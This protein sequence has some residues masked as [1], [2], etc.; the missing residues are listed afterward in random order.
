MDP[1]GRAAGQQTIPTSRPFSEGQQKGDPACLQGSKSVQ[2][3]FTSV[4]LRIHSRRLEGSGDEAV[5]SRRWFQSGGLA[6]TLARPPR[7]AKWGHFSTSCLGLPEAL[8]QLL[9]TGNRQE[10]VSGRCEYCSY[11]SFRLRAFGTLCSI[12]WPH[13]PA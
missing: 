6:D 12:N 9:G 13:R 3:H 1:C 11:L 10:C 7:P 5:N 2:C 8:L 4:V